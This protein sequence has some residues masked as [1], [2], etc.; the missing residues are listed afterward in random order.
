MV[1][2]AAA[3]ILDDVSGRFRTQVQPN[4]DDTPVSDNDGSGYCGVPADRG[5]PAERILVRVAPEVT[6]TSIGSFP[7][8]FGAIPELS[9]TFNRLPR[10][11]GSASVPAGSRAA[12][13]GSAKSVIITVDIPPRPLSAR[14]EISS[15]HL[16]GRLKTASHSC[17]AEP[18]LAPR[19]AERLRM[20]N[21][22]SER[23]GGPAFPPVIALRLSV[24]QNP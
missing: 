19:S 2:F 20:L 23:T 10:A 21:Q 9:R 7:G 5:V 8:R 11:V 13:V 1:V 22:H 24:A 4:I 16:R 17:R 3:A 14:L 18:K 12:L 15:V 6:H